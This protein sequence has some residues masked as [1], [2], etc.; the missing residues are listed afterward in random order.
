M[1]GYGY[2]DRTR[3]GALDFDIGYGYDNGVIETIDQTEALFCDGEAPTT[4]S[5]GELS[6]TYSGRIALFDS[7]SSIRV[8]ERAPYDCRAADY[9]VAFA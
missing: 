7:P 3:H 2:F 4:I 5:E 8:Y 1:A 6:G 9:K